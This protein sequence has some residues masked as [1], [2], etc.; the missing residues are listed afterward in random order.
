MRKADEPIQPNEPS[1]GLTP[2]ELARDLLS[3]IDRANKYA[4]TRKHRFRSS[5]SAVR[6]IS[7]LLTVVSTI[8][9]GLQ[10]LNAWT[11]TAFALIAIVSTVN[12]LEPFFA[13]RSRW[14]LM[15]QMQ[16]K[17]CSIRDELS[18]YIASNQ[19]D[20]LEER[21]L[22]QF[23]D[24]YQRTWDQLTNRWMEYRRSPG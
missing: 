23:F 13:W 12:T 17:F 20:Q 15:E 18:Y 9:L 7:L 21:Q 5:S 8:I 24:A 2:L 14:V 1:P 4:R 16:S 3:R 10:E 6:L 19:P 11:G 22:R